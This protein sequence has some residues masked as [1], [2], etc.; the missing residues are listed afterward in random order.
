[1]YKIYINETPLILISK[2]DLEMHVYPRQNVLVTPY[3]GKKKFLMQYVDQLEKSKRFEAVVIHHTDVEEVWDAF[4]SLFR[5]VKAAGGLVLN[6]RKE[7]LFIYR[8]GFWDLPKGKLDPGENYREASVRE[9]KEECGLKDLTLEDKLTSTFHVFKNKS[10]K[11]ILKKTKW[12]LMTSNDRKLIPQ[13]EEDIEVAKWREIGEF[14]SSGDIA[15][16]NINDVLFTYFK[17]IK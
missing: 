2:E 17:N 9:V 8:R 13:T 11:R 5:I 4:K 12:Y 14:M 1:M 3:A 16:K 10:G 15:Y 7:V 6:S